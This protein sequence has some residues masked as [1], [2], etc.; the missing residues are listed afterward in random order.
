MQLSSGVLQQHAIG[1]ALS[2]MAIKL[3]PVGVQLIAINKPD[4]SNNGKSSYCF[5]QAS[6]FSLCLLNLHRLALTK[7]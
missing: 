4:M 3:S 6:L 5:V 1:V 7:H 2:S